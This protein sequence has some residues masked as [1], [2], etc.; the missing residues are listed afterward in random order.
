[1]KE[2]ATFMQNM[3]IVIN[4][5]ENVCV[6]ARVNLK[7]GT[8]I[9]NFLECCQSVNTNNHLIVPSDVG[10]GYACHKSEQI[11]IFTGENLFEKSLVQLP[12]A[13]STS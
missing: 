13:G 11:S 4:E 9:L 12:P 2:I 8:L 6:R 10:Q 7:S 5:V 1:M 3:R